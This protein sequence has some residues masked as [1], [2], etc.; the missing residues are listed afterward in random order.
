MG[1]AVSLRISTSRRRRRDFRR[2]VDRRVLRGARALP[3]DP[4][5]GARGRVLVGPGVARARP[6]ARLPAAA[7]A[8]LRALG[9]RPGVPPGAQGAQQLQ[10]QPQQQVGQP[11]HQ[12]LRVPEKGAVRC[13]CGRACARRRW[14]RRAIFSLSSSCAPGSLVFS[15]VLSFCRSPC[16]YCSCFWGPRYCVLRSRSLL[17]LHSV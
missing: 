6:G 3:P 17:S 13:F 16:V 4:A 10:V 8:G 7:G 2:R 15:L 1:T 11:A 9:G 12:R 14:G 5:L